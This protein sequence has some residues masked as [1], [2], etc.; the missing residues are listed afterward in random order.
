MPWKEVS[1]M[2]ERMRFVSLAQSGRFEMKKLCEE[3]GISRKSG[4]KWVERYQEQGSKGLNDRSRTYKGV[5]QQ[6]LTKARHFFQR[7]V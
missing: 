1:A 2:E 7:G 5:S 6:F 3:F 4:Y